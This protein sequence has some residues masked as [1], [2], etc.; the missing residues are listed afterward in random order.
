M[1]RTWTHGEGMFKVLS[2]FGFNFNLRPHTEGYERT[3]AVRVIGRTMFETDRL[4]K[5]HVERCN[6]MHEVWVP[7]Q[8]SAD[9]FEKS[10]VLR[11]KIRVVPEA[12]D[13]DVFDPV[14]PNEQCSPRH[15]A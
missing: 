11:E 12:V 1:T 5:G 7:T 6:K 4:D 8:W 14:E 9:V 3:N 2:S 10:G 13:V 15:P